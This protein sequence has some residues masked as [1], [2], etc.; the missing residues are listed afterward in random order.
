MLKARAS[1]RCPFID[2]T[3]GI[4]ACVVLVAETLLRVLLGKYLFGYTR[5]DQNLQGT[6]DES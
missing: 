4:L 6:S 5:M 1:F 2:Y 3:Y